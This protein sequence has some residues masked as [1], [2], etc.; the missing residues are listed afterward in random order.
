MVA[1][2][3]AGTQNGFLA[4]QLQDS[5]QSTKNRLRST[6]VIYRFDSAELP[7]YAGTVHDV[8]GLGAFRITGVTEIRHHAEWVLK[9]E[10]GDTTGLYSLTTREAFSKSGRRFSLRTVESVEEVFDLSNDKSA[11]QG[12]ERP[13]A[14]LPIGDHSW[15]VL[16]P[17]PPS[18]GV[19]ALCFSL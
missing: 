9:I 7:W 1:A 12:F 18:G 15:N 17:F 11:I 4:F 8:E 6:L 5:A 10:I 14:P 16:A 13:L 2:A 19:S 3:R